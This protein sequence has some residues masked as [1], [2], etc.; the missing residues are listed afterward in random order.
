MDISVNRTALLSCQAQGVPTPLMSW[1]KDGVLLDPGNPRW[2]PE[3]EGFR[4]ILG[5]GS[6]L[7]VTKRK[8]PGQLEQKSD[9]TQD[10]RGCRITRTGTPLTLLIC[11][12]LNMVSSPPLLSLSLSTLSATSVST[13]DTLSPPLWSM[14]ALC[15][16]QTQFPRHAMPL[17]QHV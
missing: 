10:E 7:P 15:D 1:R 6:S 17:A 12:S 4:R 8:S 13:A 9:F 3:G 2:E 14:P 16:Y 5:L 11:F